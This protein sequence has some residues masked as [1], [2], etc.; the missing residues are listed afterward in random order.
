MISLVIL[1]T[2]VLSSFG[3]PNIAQGCYDLTL[4]KDNTSLTHTL[5]LEIPFIPSFNLSQRITV[6]ALG[7]SGELIERTQVCEPE[8]FYMFTDVTNIKSEVEPLVFEAIPHLPGTTTVASTFAES[9]EDLPPLPSID[10]NSF[11]T[12][13]KPSVGQ[14]MNLTIHTA[15]SPYSGRLQL[16]PEVLGSLKVALMNRQPRSSTYAS[17]VDKVLEKFNGR[18]HPSMI[19]KKVK[20]SIGRDYAILKPLL[21]GND[22]LQKRVKEMEDLKGRVSAVLQTQL[23]TM[24]DAPNS[25]CLEPIEDLDL[26]LCFSYHLY[27][28]V[29]HPQYVEALMLLGD[30][31][32]VESK[33]A[34][35]LKILESYYQ[36]IAK[37]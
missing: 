1:L 6:R 34:I 26:L 18:V 5:N 32:V 23:I 24:V 30:Y 27:S 36:L 12:A 4:D 28:L 21:K 9:F 13:S 17:K 35:E 25:K 7:P 16:K 37:V 14:V 19:N 29:R 15:I 3:D 11:W 31:I 22:I 33:I 2:L 8:T 20:R 10:G